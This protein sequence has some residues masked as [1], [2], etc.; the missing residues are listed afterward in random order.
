MAKKMSPLFTDEKR[1][2]DGTTI[3]SKKPRAK[4][5]TMKNSLKLSVDKQKIPRHKERWP[6]LNFNRQVKLRKDYFEGIEEYVQQLNDKQKDFLNKFLE[7]TVITNFKHKGSLLYKG[8]KKR[9]EFYN[10]NNARNRCMHTMAKAMNIL[11]STETMPNLDVLYNT[12]VSND[13]F[14]NV[15]DAMLTAIE[16]KRIGAVEDAM[17][18]ADENLLAM[19]KLIKAKLEAENAKLVKNNKKA[20]KSN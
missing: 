12:E 9:R 6:A 20:R 15:E 10:S 5:N 1:T 14:N 8:K 16:L 18:E 3:P 7:E 17:K 13:G 11:D 4:R 19:A 2:D